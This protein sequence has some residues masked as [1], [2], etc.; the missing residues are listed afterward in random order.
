MADKFTTWR[1]MGEWSRAYWR[2][3]L[4]AAEIAELDACL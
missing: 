4:P 1:C 2:T 3:V